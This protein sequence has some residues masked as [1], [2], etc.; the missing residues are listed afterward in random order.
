MIP[1]PR[2]LAAALFAAAGTLAAGPVQAETPGNTFVMAR[3]LADIIT[4]DPA[5]VFELAT[6]EIMTN[7]YDRVMMFEPENLQELTG[8][9]TESYAVGEDGK[10]IT[11]RVRDGLKFHSGNPV[12]PED[13]EFSLERVV[14]LKKTPSFIVTQFG[15]N[16]DNVEDLIEVI[17]DRHVRVTIVEE[18]SPVLVLN[19]LSAGVASVIDKELV[20]SHEVDG[21]LGYEWLK[22]NSA[23]SGAFRLRS[24]KSNETVVLDA[25]SDYRHG[26]PGVTRVILRHVPEPSA[27]R[28]LLEKGDVDL[29]RNLTPDQIKGIAG[30][31]TSR[32]RAT[33]RA[34][35]STWRRTRP[36]RS[37]AMTWWCRR[38]AMRS[39]TTAW[40]TPSS[41]DSSWC[42]RR[43][44]RAACGG[45]TPRRRTRSM[46]TRRRPC[47]PRQATVT[48]SRSRSTR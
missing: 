16:A 41:P 2:T 28:L 33:R 7:V 42:T 38:C 30:N 23:G 34:A 35:S 40:P 48:V 11:F 6:G 47:W 20:L 25:N 12:R 32:C 8:G 45:R 39:T 29:A 46:S 24:W 15:W 10:T 37:S 26:A 31:P 3:D 5:E 36:T 18:F 27:Q 17:D 14:K 1:T 22:T 9:V 13:V 4:M 19:A 44:G 43:S 21:D